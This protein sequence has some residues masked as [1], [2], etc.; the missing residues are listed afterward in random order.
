MNKYTQFIYELNL[1]A[2]RASN[3][4]S[5][6]SLFKTFATLLYEPSLP[7]SSPSTPNNIN[8]KEN[9]PITC[10]RRARQ[11]AWSQPNMQTNPFQTNPFSSANPRKALMV[12]GACLDN[13]L[14]YKIIYYFTRKLHSHL[15]HKV[16]RRYQFI[17]QRDI[18]IAT[19]TFLSYRDVPFYFM[20]S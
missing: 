2:A 14:F 12:N 6:H 19:R 16:A 13:L 15:H 20:D 8:A 11:L 9:N 18:I 7:G 5:W 1:V 3:T 4:S 17:F 10:R